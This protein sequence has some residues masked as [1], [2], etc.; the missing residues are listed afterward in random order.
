MSGAGDFEQDGTSVDVSVLVECQAQSAGG[1]IDAVAAS[2]SSSPH[3]S[4]A[5]EIPCLRPINQRQILPP[6]AT[7]VG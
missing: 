2:G 3:A 5:F 7:D 1:G 4:Q 6:V